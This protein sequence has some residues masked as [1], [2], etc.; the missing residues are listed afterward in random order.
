MYD[1][2]DTENSEI[3]TSKFK[4]KF[5]PKLC[6]NNFTLISH[7]TKFGSLLLQSSTQVFKKNCRNNMS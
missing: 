7:L 2:C 1:L 6:I 3:W 5:Y 4:L